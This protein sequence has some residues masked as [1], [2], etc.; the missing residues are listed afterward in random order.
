[1]DRETAINL[2]KAYKSL[3]MQHFDVKDV[4]LYGSYGKGTQRQD[5]DIDIAV[6]V[7]SVEGD[8]FDYVPLLWKLRRQVSN[9]IEP[10]LIWG[11]NDISGFLKNIRQTGI[12]L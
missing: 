12:I 7:N 10:V 3:V 9:L 6:V 1:M 8:Y 5:S 2:G 11:D 4:I